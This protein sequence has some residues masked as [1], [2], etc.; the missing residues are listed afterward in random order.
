MG[1]AVVALSR[2]DFLAYPVP[3]QTPERRVLVVL[4]DAIEERLELNRDGNVYYVEFPNSWRKVRFIP[5]L[6]YSTEIRR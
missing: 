5:S 6:S 2:R 1:S 4:L 3:L